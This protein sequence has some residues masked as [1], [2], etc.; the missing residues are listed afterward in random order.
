MKTRN[1]G[2][3]NLSKNGRALQQQK[4]SGAWNGAV[5]QDIGKGLADGPMTGFAHSENRL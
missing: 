3:T 2:C 5:Q 4:C 1:M